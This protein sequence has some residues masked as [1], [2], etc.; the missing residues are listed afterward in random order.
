MKHAFKI[1]KNLFLSTLIVSSIFFGM[2]PA[3]P[4]QAAAWDVTEG[5]ALSAVFTGGQ[6]NSVGAFENIDST[7]VVFATFGGGTS[8]TLI[9]VFARD[10]SDVL[11]QVGSYTTLDNDGGVGIDLHFITSTGGSSYYLAVFLGAGGDGFARVASVNNSTYAITVHGTALEFDT[12]DFNYGSLEQLDTN[13]FLVAWKGTSGFGYT[14]TLEV[15]T[16]TWAVT[17]TG[18]GYTFDGTS[19]DYIDTAK[20][21]STHVLVTWSDSAGDGKAIVVEV[22]GSWNITNSDAAFEFDTSDATYNETEM[23]DSTHFIIAWRGVSGDG[24]VQAFVI[25]GSYAITT[26]GSSLE[27]DATDSSQNHLYPVDA[28]HLLLNWT[29]G[30]TALAQVLTVDTGTW[31]ITEEGTQVDFT[32]EGNFNVL[33]HDIGVFADGIYV[34]YHIEVNSSTFARDPFMVV[35]DVE[36]PAGGT[37]IKTVNTTAIANVK[38][39]TGAAVGNIKSINGIE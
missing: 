24:F 6:D 5:D 14:R 29:N 22:D 4:V 15:N 20:F 34:N 33:N 37:S 9:G 18:T 30:S 1:L 11:S 21:D 36:L 12:A 32:Q 35:F 26:A 39:F 25:D 28:E 27:Y 7:H 16:S 2:Q 13:H 17:A 10:G 3:L 31:A 23:V 19:A 8:D 38:T